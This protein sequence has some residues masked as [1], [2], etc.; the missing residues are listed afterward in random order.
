[1]DTCIKKITEKTYDN[2]WKNVFYSSKFRK[3]KF[4]EMLKEK[5]HAY[6]APY[7][8][9]FHNTYPFPLPKISKKTTKKKQQQQQQQKKKKKINLWEM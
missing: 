8:P 2:F 5:L 9:H 1:M 4:K 3:Y 6:I 7:L